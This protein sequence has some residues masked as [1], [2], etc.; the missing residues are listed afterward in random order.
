MNDAAPKEWEA[1]YRRNEHPW[2]KGEPSPGLVDF[3]RDRTELVPGT[4]CVPGC[5]F[6]HDARQ[7]ARHGFR[8]TGIDISPTA[9]KRAREAAER[10]D[11]PVRFQVADFLADEP[12]TPFD[13]VFEHTFFCAIEPDQRERYVR[14]VLRWLRPGGHYLAVYYLLQEE[15][16]PPYPVDRPEILERFASRFDLRQEW[17]PRS[18]EHRVDLE[19]MIWWTAKASS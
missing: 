15:D 16:G 6:G 9:V 14:S 18:W 10:D 4:V 8:V 12:E 1:R 19:L 3:L 11:L 2:D 5:G 13:W 7:W 17:R